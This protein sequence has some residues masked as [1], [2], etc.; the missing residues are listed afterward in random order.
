M[1]SAAAGFL[2]TAEG[3]SNS[4]M[5]SGAGC[6]C[7]SSSSPSLSTSSWSDSHSS[8]TGGR[9]LAWTLPFLAMS[10]LDAMMWR[11]AAPNAALLNSMGISP[12]ELDEPEPRG[13]CCGCCCFIKA[14]SAP[15]TPANPG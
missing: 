12:E 1:G 9:A 3:P 14:S 13:D 7:S 4:T 10:F 5:A 8:S 6:C 2:P 15:R 11:L